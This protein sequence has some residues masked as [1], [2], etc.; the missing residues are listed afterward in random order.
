M[1]KLILV[2]FTIVGLTA[3][4]AVRKKDHRNEGYRSHSITHRASE[5][6]V[7]CVIYKDYYAGGLSCN[8]DKYNKEIAK[9]ADEHQLKYPEF[10]DVVERCENLL[11]NKTR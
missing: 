9:C 3:C 8:W 2:S 11:R 5:Q 1:K 10:P 4:D 7:E 6:G